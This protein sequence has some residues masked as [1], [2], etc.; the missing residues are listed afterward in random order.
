MQ[1]A[2]KIVI[3]AVL[4]MLVV[5]H[6]LALILHIINFAQNVMTN[7]IQMII[8]KMDQVVKNV[9]QATIHIKTAID[10]AKSV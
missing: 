6:A 1:N 9:Y 7:A 8:V 5:R 4:I 10:I 3:A 2:I